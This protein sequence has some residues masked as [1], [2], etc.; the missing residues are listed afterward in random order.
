MVL[1]SHD[2]LVSESQKSRKNQ[3]NYFFE[4]KKTGHQYRLK[5]SLRIEWGHSQPL[6]I[7][8]KHSNLHPKGN[9]FVRILGGDSL[10]S[11]LGIQNFHSAQKY[12]ADFISLRHRPEP[13]QASNI[14]VAGVR[15][16]TDTQ[17]SGPSDYWST[18]LSSGTTT[19][20]P[21]VEF[22]NPLCDG[23]SW[24]HISC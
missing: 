24:F 8:L 5:I 7:T 22:I 13:A 14:G 4:E 1:Y 2:Y 18:H 6:K 21:H 11:E 9:I 3:K 23:S 20:V 10:K 19:T 15:E 16:V 17:P 12:S